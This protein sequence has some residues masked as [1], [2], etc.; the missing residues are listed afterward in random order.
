MVVESLIEPCPA[1]MLA[2]WHH[3]LVTCQLYTCSSVLHCSSVTV[4]SLIEAG[5]LNSNIIELGP[6]CTS[7]G[8]TVVHSVIRAYCVISRT[9]VWPPGYFALHVINIKPRILVF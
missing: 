9:A 6:N 3:P 8:S 4:F 5:G 2:L 7:P 1:V